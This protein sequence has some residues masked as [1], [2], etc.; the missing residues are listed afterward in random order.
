MAD[1]KSRK[2]TPN[3][4]GFDVRQFLNKTQEKVRKFIATKG[5]TSKQMAKDTSGKLKSIHGRS[6]KAL[7]KKR[8][9][10]QW[11]K[12]FYKN[13]PKDRWKRTLWLLHPRQQFKFWFSRHGAFFA[14][15]IML[16]GFAS[17]L[18]L[19][20]GA[21]AYYSQDLPNPEE[22]ND[23]LLNQSTRFYDRS[24]EILL[25]ETFGDQDRTLVKFEEISDYVK[26]ATVAAED[27]DF[28][29]HH[30]IDLSAITR[31]G[32]AYVVNRG[33][34]TQGGSTIT[35]QF[36]KKS[37]LTDDQTWERKI[38]EAILSL[39]LE[40]IYTKEEILTF[41]LN[42]VPYGGTSYGIQAA[43]E[44]YFGTTASEV[45][46][47]QAALL[48][49]LPQRPT[50]FINNLDHL[51]LRKNY[52]LDQ[53]LEQGHITEE[54]AQAAKDKD[55]VSKMRFDRN[56]YKG[57]KAPHF[58]LEA[59]R[60]LE[61][62]YGADVVAQGGLDVITT[63]D[64]DLQKEAEKA[65][66]DNIAIVDAAGGNN[67]A[68]VSEDSKTGQVL[69]MVGSRDFF[70]P[71]FGNY[72]AATARRQ[73]GSSFKPYTYATLMKENYGAGSVFYDVPT[74]F[75]TPSNP[76]EPRNFD[77]GFRGAL[78]M[79]QSIAESRNIPAV[80]ALYMAGLE[81]VMEQTEKQG[82]SL[83]G[84]PSDYGLSLT[85]GAGEVTP[86][87]HTHGYTTFANGGTSYD[88]S[89]ILKVT[90]ARGEVLEEWKDE[91]GEDVLDEEIAYL[92]THMLT[93]RA[94]RT[95]TFGASLRYFE[96]PDTQVAVKTGTT[97]DTRD[98]WL[99][100][101]STNIT[102]GV[103]V[104]HNDNHELHRSS[105]QMT[106]P[107][108]HQYMVAAHELKPAEDFKRPEGIKSV[109]LDKYT[110][111]VPLE[112][113]STTVTELFPS[114]Y[115]APSSSASEP[116]VID[117]VS[118]K[119]ATECTPEAAKKEVRAGGIDAEIPP[120][121]PAYPRWNAPVQSYANDL[122]LGS[123]GSGVATKPTEEDD[124]HD[125][126]D[127]KPTVNSFEY[128]EDNNVLRAS[129]S[130]GTFNLDKLE[131]RIDGQIISGGNVDISG[132]KASKT[133]SVPSKYS[134]SHKA[135][136]VVIDKGLYQ[137]EASESITVSS[138]GFSASVDKN[139]NNVTFTW[140]KDPDDDVEQY[141]IF[142]DG[143]K[144]DTVNKNKTSWT[145]SNYCLSPT[146]SGANTW[147]VQSQEDDGDAINTASGSFKCN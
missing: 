44:N 45:T 20:I 7:T 135:R 139:G 25:Y 114:W 24:G 29:N 51:S 102:T 112:G 136:V 12:E 10:S 134:G 131:F 80:K 90:N 111:R 56:Q 37:L 115:K 119:L 138:S 46:L 77:H 17:F 98:G 99:M 32:F 96:V 124:V 68:L 69:A 84:E 11:H 73:P 118:N 117:T 105:S 121:D 92:M 123:G 13:A 58:V 107:I 26:D 142:I 4:G 71:D 82:V 93:D 1:K 15:K 81:N 87:E 97:N 122:N 89:Y 146:N 140:T 106:G 126:D 137:N 143:S 35:Q 9:K 18:L 100:G 8:R 144:K 127:K 38:K 109:T 147:K 63:V 54:E 101:Y 6:K 91:G 27:S 53:M 64:M 76:Y 75:G 94:S 30:G 78:T 48:A 36:I 43:A 62:K 129:V 21:Y 66:K 85:L 57:I 39:E 132:S 40:R 50:Y 113:S 16:I 72:N 47:D 52:V 34:I 104:G 130:K 70:H 67:A 86:A 83:A 61:D 19:S 120:S 145:A 23:R 133:V 5:I 103:W 88:Q 125:C 74:N 79:H 128:D 14:G 2:K 31:A 95:P 42:E 65:V 141:A 108:W 55:T 60:I 22:I 116:F 33:Q 49:A 3:S 110:G 28:Y 41:Y 59:R